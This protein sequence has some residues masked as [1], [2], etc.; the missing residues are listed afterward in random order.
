MGDMYIREIYMGNTAGCAGP[1]PFTALEM[2]P[3][4]FARTIAKILFYFDNVIDCRAINGNGFSPF[5][6][7][8][9][10]INSRI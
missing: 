8:I 1:Q 10:F 6:G 4:G 3:P 2:T 9:K 7:I 5:R